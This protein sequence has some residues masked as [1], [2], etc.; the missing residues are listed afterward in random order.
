M[1][2]TKVIGTFVGQIHL[3]KIVNIMLM[4]QFLVYE[5]GNSFCKYA[6]ET[7]QKMQISNGV[8][9]RFAPP[10]HFTRNPHEDINNE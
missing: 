2:R 8:Y 4:A 7:T 10:A 6:Q 3:T 9:A 5:F 1:K